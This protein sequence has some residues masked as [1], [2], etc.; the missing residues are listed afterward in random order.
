MSSKSSV[1][2]AARFVSRVLCRTTGP[3]RYCG[4]V[5]LLQGNERHRFA[6]G[7]R[8]LHL[9]AQN[10]VGLPSKRSSDRLSDTRTVRTSLQWPPDS[11]RSRD[12]RRSHRRLTTRPRPTDRRR[13]FATSLLFVTPHTASMHPKNDNMHFVHSLPIDFPVRT[14]SISLHCHVILSQQ[15]AS[16]RCCNLVFEESYA[17]IRFPNWRLECLGFAS[18]STRE[19][20]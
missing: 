17:R 18:H 10:I 8:E 6:V 16:H 11:H 20:I 2:Q 19:C 4:E 5:Q 12:A 7:D 13:T 3:C 9:D 14:T 1:P 15:C